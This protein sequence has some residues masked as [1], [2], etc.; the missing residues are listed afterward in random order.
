MSESALSWFTSYLANRRQCVK[1]NDVLS[2]YEQIEFGVP[3]GSVVGPT[4]FTI[5][6]NDLLLSL[7]DGCAIAY[8]DDLT[9]TASDSKLDIAVSRLQDLLSVVHCWSEHNALYLNTLKCF[10]M[11]IRPSLRGYQAQNINI[12]LGSHALTKVQKL[13]LLGVIISDDLSWTCQSRRVRAKVTSRMAAIKRFGRCLNVNT[14]L[15]AYNAFIKPH[16]DYCL[17]V[18]G[19]TCTSVASELDRTLARCLRTISGSHTSTFSRASLET[20]GI[21]D[22]TTHVFISNVL[23]IHKQLHLPTEH[24]AFNPCLLTA[25]HDTQAS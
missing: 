10:V 13:S 19:N 1:Y 25:S 15:I 14:R 8:A 23:A 9:I 4:M 18:W 7:P 16:L 24:R 22:F 6:V 17:P 20:Y 21:C 2:D 12:H 3:Q 5:Y 11:H